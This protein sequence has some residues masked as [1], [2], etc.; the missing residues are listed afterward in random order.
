MV[1]VS[2]SNT[3]PRPR[4][5]TLGST[6]GCHHRSCSWLS[7]AARAGQGRRASHHGGSSCRALRHRT[8]TGCTAGTCSPHR[9]LSRHDAIRLRVTTPETDRRLHLLR[10]LGFHGSERILLFWACANGLRVRAAVKATSERFMVFI[11]I[12]H[13]VRCSI[14]QFK[15]P[16][17]LSW[18]ALI[19][20]MRVPRCTPGLFAL[21]SAQSSK[22]GLVATPSG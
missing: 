8:R 4:S 15:P 5:G 3:G 7:R 9:T 17:V 20:A 13:W 22:N 10:A 1:F 16:V 6:R 21:A 12:P 2:L 18:M 14:H 19:C 11:N